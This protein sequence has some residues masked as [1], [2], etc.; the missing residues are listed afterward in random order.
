VTSKLTREIIDRIFREPGIK[1]EL[2]DFESLGKPIHEILTIYPKTAETGRDAG[3]TKYYLESFIPFPSGNEEVQ[4]YV[5][6]G[7]SAPEEIVRQLWVYKLIHQYGYR[8]DEIDLEKS[9]QFGTEVGTKA[10]DIIVYTDAAKETPKIIV[11]C[12]KPKRKDGI[13]Q[14]K[15]YMNAKGA[16]VAIW[17]NGSDSIIL[18]RPYPKDFDDTLYDIPKRGQQPKDVLDT[19]KTLLQLRREFNFKKIIQDLE[20][21]V[22][23]DSGKDE[24]NEIF[25][26][27]FAKI[28]DEKEAQENKKRNKTVEFSKAIDPDITYDRI[29]R[30]F[31]EACKEWPGIFKEGEDIEL[32]KRHLQVCVGPIEGVRLM[33]SNL[34][35]MDDAFE[36]LLPTE[37]KK[38]KG[39]FFTP[40][41]VVEMCVRMLNPKQN[42]YVMDP[43]CGSG[44][45]LL[46]AMDWCYPARDQD[47]REMRKFKYASKYLWGVDFETRAAK[48][49]RAL[50]LI[51]GDGHTNIFG[52]DVSSLDPK[53]WYETASGQALMHG[54]R[55]AKLVG[56]KI[57]ESDIL[58]DDDHAW[59]YFDELKFDV[60]LTNPPF[61]GEM[62]DRKML[63]HY[64]L[65]KP[66]LKRARDKAPK[67]ERDV[68]F[69]ERVLKM[70]KPGG[71]AAIVLPQGKFNNSSLAFIR[72]W[73]LK[74]ARLLAVVGLHPNT[75]KPHTG[76]K[77]SVMLFQKYTMQELQNIQQVKQDV[78]V[79]CPDYGAEIRALLEVYKNEDD[80]PDEAIPEALADL[81]QESFG[82]PET[83]DETASDDAQHQED[84]G[85]AKAAEDRLDYTLRDQEEIAGDRLKE[86]R[87]ALIRT[88]S[89]LIDLDSDLEALKEQHA[90]E[91]D[92]I[93]EHWKDDPG[94]LKARLKEI[95]DNHKV[96]L[97]TLQD[98]QK[99]K[100]KILKAEIKQLEKEIPLAEYNLKLLSNRGK[101]ALILVDPDLI[102]TLKERW[103]AAEV[104][105]RL[106]YPIFMAVSERGGKNNSGDYEYVVDK[107]GSLVEFPDGHPQEGQLVV[108]QDLVNYDLKADDLA[109]AARIPDDKRCVAEAFVRFA[110]EQGFDFW[111]AE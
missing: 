53:T 37:A 64:D 42:E 44:G 49:S 78:A 50:M 66:A 94:A 77:T 67:E 46:H 93:A 30:L 13:E 95:K 1:Y 103:I 90:Q 36:Y 52:P 71:R 59:D 12:K 80:V 96:A 104:A 85:F 88:K 99:T 83:D 11:E 21:L 98:K 32:A 7:K 54:L 69:I 110:Q 105:K 91:I 39:Q 34:R 89:K 22:L 43:A 56:K 108:D 82:E 62:K 26:L 31:Q 75:F 9:V 102:G 65:A 35:V 8:D 84:E 3:K 45:F 47:V 106:D 60:I 16:P 19:K 61:A 55:Q 4:V 20:E 81:I 79:A 92:V 63:I 97:K 101:L 68:L 58:K 18:Y 76:T 100:Q 10:A 48:T 6:G 40:R 23:A 109:D 51:A 29:N 38:K 17:S 14:L 57:P 107:D 74:N 111:R 2:T 73:I 5:E 41:H 25:K 33:G 24:F 70:L 87:A 15:S 27:I 72:E 28:W 86:L